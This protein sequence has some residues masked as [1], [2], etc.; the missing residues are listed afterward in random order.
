MGIPFVRLYELPEEGHAYWPKHVAVE[1]RS[2]ERITIVNTGEFIVCTL[3]T[4]HR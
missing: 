1:N 2:K 3:S 4:K